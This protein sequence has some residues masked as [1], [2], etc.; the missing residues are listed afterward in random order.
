MDRKKMGFGIPVEKWLSNELK[1]LVQDYLSPQKLGE[2]GL[3]SIPQ[4]EKL[5]TA[6]FGGR[7]ELYLKIWYL[8]MFQMWYEKWIVSE[9]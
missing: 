1:D 5:K 6:F 9:K 4:V 8:L 7:T 3:F 2:H